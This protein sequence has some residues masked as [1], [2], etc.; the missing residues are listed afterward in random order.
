MHTALIDNWNSRVQKGDIVYF[1][2]DFS[3]AKDFTK[4]LD[5]FLRLNGEKHLI[6]GNHDKNS[7]N[8]DWMSKYEIKELNIH[9]KHIVLCHYRMMVWNRSHH[10][11]LHFY[12]HSH[13]KNTETSQTCDIGVDNWN[14]APTSLPEILER[15]NKAPKHQPADY[16]GKSL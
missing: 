8:L 5:V 1:L 3:F 11:S 9:N 2:G 10:G 15:L 12:G 4:T 7:Y 6:K 14:Y 13:S 16:H